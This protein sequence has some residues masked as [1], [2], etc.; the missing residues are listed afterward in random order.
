[1]CIV[2]I[3]EAAW[4]KMPNGDVCKNSVE[5]AS[6][7]LNFMSTSNPLPLLDLDAKR[8]RRTSGKAAR[9]SRLSQLETCMNETETNDIEGKAKEVGFFY[10]KGIGLG[11]NIA[12]LYT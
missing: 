12:V 2:H 7:E 3:S 8:Q 10:G 1:M 11:N 9:R 5:K 4:N 6:K